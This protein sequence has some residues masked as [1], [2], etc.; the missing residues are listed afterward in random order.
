[1]NKNGQNGIER[2][3]C[4]MVVSFSRLTPQTTCLYTRRGLWVE[5]P[6]AAVGTTD[7]PVQNNLLLEYRNQP[8]LSDG[9]NIAILKNGMVEKRTIYILSIYC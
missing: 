8:R 3:H 1:M 5:F 6:P 7:V 9:A 2:C 4:P